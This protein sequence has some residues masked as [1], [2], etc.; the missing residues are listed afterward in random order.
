MGRR[1]SLLFAI[2]K[3]I[4]R[5]QRHSAAASAQALREQERYIAASE[6]AQIKYEKEAQRAL[7]ALDKLEAQQ[8][9]DS[10]EQEIS[11]LNFGIQDKIEALS[12]ILTHTL[13]VDDSIDFEA[14]KIQDSFKPFSPDPSL[15]RSTPAPKL[16]DFLDRVEQ[17]SALRKILPGA[18]KKMDKLRWTAQLEFEKQHELW[19]ELESRRLEQLESAKFEH[20]KALA[21]FL[22]K[23]NERNAEVEA[24]EQAYLSGDPDAIIVY[25]SMVLERSNY[26]EGLP[27]NFSLSYTSSSKMLVVEYQLPSVEVIP[28]IV[29]YT[30]AR[31]KDTLSE[32]LRKP[33]EIKTIYQD[34]VASIA[35]RTIH[36]I[37]EADLARIVEVV[38]FN[39]YVHTVDPA[40]GH[41]IQ[42]HLIS[43]RTTR[44]KFMVIDLE[45]VDKT[46]CLRNLGAQVSRNPEEAR[47]IKPIVEFEMADA[48]FVDQ[49]DLVSGLATATNLMDLSPFQFEE[50]V[51]NL[52][53]Q[54][55]LESKLTRSTRD[56]GVDCVAFDNRPVLGGKVVI[57]A[58]R[59]KNTVGVSAVRDLYGTMLNEGAN[60]GILVTTSGYGPDAF[61]FAKDKPIELIEGGGLL[62]LL[63]EIGVSARIIFP[64]E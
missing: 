63:Q 5:A 25:N 2:A 60:K 16:S 50:L 22:S 45:R 4:A 7:N 10:R 14:L 23:K 62:Y 26:P 40:N 24:F 8:Y 9:L 30:Y 43:V 11:E 36:E 32:K 61:E 17:I 38:C 53:G 64:T 48:R 52:F 3:D 27:Q 58:K 41:D 21:D 57:Q 13:Q 35:L 28:S 47:P 46:I 54:M 56:G 15:L 1:R 34:L 33:S 19:Q 12:N 44:D 31:S 39:G 59:Y 55:G 29:A 18:K 6:K 51:S 37:L 42:P 20:S 49:S